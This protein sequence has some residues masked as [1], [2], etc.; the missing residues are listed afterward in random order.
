[1]SKV[2]SGEDDFPVSGSDKL[3]RL[4]DYFIGG[5]A[6]EIRTNSGD[7]AECAIQQTAILHLHEGPLMTVKSAYEPREFANTKWPE[8]LLK[9]CLILDYFDDAGQ[10]RHGIRI[11]GGITAHD[12]NGGPGVAL[13]QPPHGLAALGIAFT[14]D[15]TRIHHAQISRFGF[16]GLA[17]AIGLESLLDQLRL[18]LIYFAAQGQ[19]SA[20]PCG[21]HVEMICDLAAQVR[22]SKRIILISCE[23]MNCALFQLVR[24]AEG[25]PVA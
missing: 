21:S 14:G 11:T 4:L 16:I 8:L 18:I 22:S 9:L 25:I 10:A 6:A 5:A 7:D 15:S 24:S 20:G 17:I 19:Q 2:N 1:M 23:F 12:D 3:S 13:V